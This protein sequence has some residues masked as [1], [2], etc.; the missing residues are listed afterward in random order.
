MKGNIMTIITNPPQYLL[1]TVFGMSD[2]P[3]SAEIVRH[4][5]SYGC[6]EEYSWE[7]REYRAYNLE[8]Q[9]APGT[10]GDFQPWA[11]AEFMDTIW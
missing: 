5:P 4:P 3:F 9:Q 7:L 6:P 1:L 10:W 2:L 8:D 11:R